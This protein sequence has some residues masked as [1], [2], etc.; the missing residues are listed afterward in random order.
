MDPSGAL[1]STDIDGPFSGAIEL[2]QKLAESQQVADCVAY[3]WLRYAL[4]LDEQQINLPAASSISARFR[5]SG[6]AF[7][8][9]LMAVVTSDTFRQLRVAH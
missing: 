1:T 7:T 8:D 3:S 5:S 6:G 9:L 4:G 2:S